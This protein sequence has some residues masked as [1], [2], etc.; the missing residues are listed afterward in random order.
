M[1]VQCPKCEKKYKVDS[2]K[3]TEKGAKIKCANCGHTFV[4]RKKSEEEKEDFVPCSK[5]GGPATIDLD[6]DNPICENCKTREEES[7]A[8]FVPMGDEDMV[9]SPMDR[10]LHLGDSGG[11][12][13]FDQLSDGDFAPDAYSTDVLPGKGESH[14]APDEAFSGAKEETAPPPVSEPKAMEDAAEPSTPPQPA[15][16]PKPPASHKPPPQPTAPTEPTPPPQPAAAQ[17]T[18]P[19]EP[20]PP[21]EPTPPPAEPEAEKPIPPAV[22]EPALPPPRSVVKPERPQKTSPVPLI[23]AVVLLLALLVYALKIF[24]IL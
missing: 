23:I 7:A 3:I 18:P 11:G 5:C 10:E 12:V 19:P 24:G 2:S 4:V 6:T 13:S 17:P 21:P 14:M 20:S 16:K 1:V 9:G 8:R 22:K 15:A